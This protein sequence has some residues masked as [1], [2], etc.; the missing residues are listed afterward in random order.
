M[1]RPCPPGVEA[2]FN[3]PVPVMILEII[4]LNLNI[5]EDFTGLAS[6]TIIS[7]A[8]CPQEMPNSGRGF[9]NGR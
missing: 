8:D 3:H 6:L 7:S 1:K 4:S 2:I 5:P 9:R